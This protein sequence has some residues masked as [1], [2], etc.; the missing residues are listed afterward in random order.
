MIFSMNRLVTM[1]ILIMLILFL[2][3]S[4]QSYENLWIQN[5]IKK[6]HDYVFSDLVLT[7]WY[8]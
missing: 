1:P 5:S 8:E 3:S 4:Y 2:H 7:G 6:R